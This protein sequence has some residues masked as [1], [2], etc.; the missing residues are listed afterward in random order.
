LIAATASLWF[1]ARE[2]SHPRQTP[3]ASTRT[4]SPRTLKRRPLCQGRET[5][6]AGMVDTLQGF[7]ALWKRF[8]PPT[9]DTP[10]PRSTATIAQAFIALG[11]I[12]EAQTTV[13]A[14]I[15]ELIQQS[16]EYRR[17]TYGF[18]TVTTQTLGSLG[19]SATD[20]VQVLLGGLNHD[21]T[22]VRIDTADALGKIGPAAKEAIP[23]RTTAMNDRTSLPR[24]RVKAAQALWRI[25]RRHR[26]SEPVLIEVLKSGEYFFERRDAA[27]ILK[28]IGPP[29]RLAIA[30]LKA[31]Q[32]DP[33]PQVRRV[34]AEAIESIGE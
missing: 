27:R 21:F 13:P 20:D 18:S 9:T 33:H 30:A 2:T 23:L 5:G 15:D 22:S 16:A 24:A 14:L 31:A 32:K 4:I 12:R 6:S 3:N 1:R 11:R 10:D 8:A 19:P 25:D 17:G 29:A 26:E 34:A 7:G 28:E